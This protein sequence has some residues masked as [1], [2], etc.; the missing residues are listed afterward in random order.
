MD[1]PAVALDMIRR[2]IHHES[3][4]DFLL[5]IEGLSFS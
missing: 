1:Q 4:Q 3:F 5:P 2:F